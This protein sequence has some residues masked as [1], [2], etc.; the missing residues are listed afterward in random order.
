MQ[1]TVTDSIAV[2]KK[3]LSVEIAHTSEQIL[4]AKRLRYRV[5]CQERGFE[6]GVNDIEQDEFDEQSRHVL[7]RSRHHGEVYGTVR[8]ALCHE[9]NPFSRFPMEQL[10]GG[11]VLASLP[12]AR[13]GE[14]SRFA[15]TRARTGLSPA[16]SALL[17]V[18]LMQG[19]VQIAG[20]E[21]LT[22]LC[23]LMEKTLLRLL[24]ATAIHF[25]PIG[26]AFEHRGLRYPSIWSI[27]EGLSR[28]RHENARIWSYITANGTLWSASAIETRIFA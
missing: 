14:V 10:V 1:V 12:R 2:A 23:A 18:C 5:Y 17:R 22:H 25:R 9:I 4:E 21:G 19:I 15:L 20:E 6:P 13:T 7:V 27:G 11:S 28:A 26:P 16:A 24:Q 8:V 3:E